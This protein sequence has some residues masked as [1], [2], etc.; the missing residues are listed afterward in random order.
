MIDQI[1]MSSGEGWIGIIPSP[2]FN[3]NKRVIHD[4]ACHTQ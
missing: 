1:G 3:I 4:G 2:D